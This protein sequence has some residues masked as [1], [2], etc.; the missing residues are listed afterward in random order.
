MRKGLIATSGGVVLPLDSLTDLGA[1]FAECSDEVS[2]RRNRVDRQHARARVAH[3]C[4]N[5]R[6]HIRAV[7]VHWALA[8]G[9]FIRLESAALN[10]AQGVGAQFFAFR[11]QLGRWLV[12]GAAVNLD[13]AGNGLLFLQ[14]GFFAVGILGFWHRPIIHERKEEAAWDIRP[15]FPIPLSKTSGN[16]PK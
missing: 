11:A 12:P 9:G 4:P 2:D 1:G 10:T 15:T 13:H 7:A 3:H 8:A 6:A 14:D 5:A 16:P